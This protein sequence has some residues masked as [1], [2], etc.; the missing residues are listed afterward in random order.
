MCWSHR[1]GEKLSEK[2]RISYRAKVSLWGL[3]V[4]EGVQKWG[5][6]PNCCFANSVVAGADA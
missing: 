4:R 3:F 1:V 5:R 2:R 6:M